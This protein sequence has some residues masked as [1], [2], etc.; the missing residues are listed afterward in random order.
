MP[1]FSIIIPV[2]NVAPYLREC[3]DS[4]LAQTFADWEAICVDDGSTDESGAI[5]DE[6]AARDK[7][8][9]VIHKEN[10]GVSSA[11][12]YALDNVKG[13]YVGFV[14]GDDWILPDWFKTFNSIIHE[15]PG[16]DWVRLEN[17]D[18]INGEYKRK[19]FAGKKEK[20]ESVQIPA[21]GWEAIVTNGVPFVNV[22][23]REIL[24]ENRFNPELKMREDAIFTLELLPAI[25][26]CVSYKYDGYVYRILES[27]ATRKKKP[28][29]VSVSFQKALLSVW[30]K[31]KRIF[32]KAMKRKISKAYAFLIYKDINQ[33]YSVRDRDSQEDG[34]RLKK[35]CRSAWRSGAISFPIKEWRKFLRFYWFMLTGDFKAFTASLFRR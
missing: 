4:V 6:Y 11:R 35:I 26:S 22:Y 5:L 21:W 10:G 20:I 19:K 15:N 28:V 32:P 31:Q 9:R 12:N 23:R 24:K 27:S 33:W 3:L 7:R 13:E 2:Y 8:F 1:K 30:E 34:D 16:I 14:D 17:R 18:F 29:D 25:K